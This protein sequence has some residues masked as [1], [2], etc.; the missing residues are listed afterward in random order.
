MN[1]TLKPGSLPP[2]GC[3][4]RAGVAGHSSVK[5]LLPPVMWTEKVDPQ[6]LHAELEAA[7]RL[8]GGLASR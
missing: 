7:G 4:R 2:L 3:L 5:P 1:V 8:P 6:E